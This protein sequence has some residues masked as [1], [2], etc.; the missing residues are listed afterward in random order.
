MSSHTL[1]VWPEEYAAVQSGK[2]N[3]SVRL[4]DRGIKVDDV[5]MFSEF[6]P[7]ENRF[8]G[9]SILR[10]VTYIHDLGQYGKGLEGYI[11]MSLTSID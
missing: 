8:T 6:E 11:G 7:Q 4:N 5:I 3:W 2:M 10:K 9:R 1:K